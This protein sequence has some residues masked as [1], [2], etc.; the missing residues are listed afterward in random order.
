MDCCLNIGCEQSLSLFREI[1]EKQGGYAMMQQNADTWTT[2]SQSM[3]S[4]SDRVQRFQGGDATVTRDDAI[5]AQEILER[6]ARIANSLEVSS[7]MG[8]I[9]GMADES[10]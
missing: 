8:G 7:S 4:A 5:E 1:D 3:V 2:M 9:T 6:G 10:T